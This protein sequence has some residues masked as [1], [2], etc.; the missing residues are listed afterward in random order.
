MNS[1]NLVGR[2]TK[3]VEVRVGSNGNDVARF[4]VAVYRNQDETDFINCVAFGKT[5]EVMGK[6]GCTS[7]GDMIAVNG[8]LKTGHYTN[9][10]G[11]EVYTTDVWCNSVKGMT[12]K[13]EYR[14][15][16]QPKRSSKGNWK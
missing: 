14:E 8:T 16:E 13:K 5:V 6:F 9:K 1:V 11:N 4:T 12:S 7:K 3:D 10:D 15:P 2:L